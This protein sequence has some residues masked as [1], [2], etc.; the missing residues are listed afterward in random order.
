MPRNS[1][2]KAIKTLG[3]LIDIIAQV[4]FYLWIIVAIVL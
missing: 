3:K 4:A 1:T 2:E